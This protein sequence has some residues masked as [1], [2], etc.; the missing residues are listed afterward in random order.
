MTGSPDKASLSVSFAWILV[1]KSKPSSA[2]FGE[3]GAAQSD[4]ACGLLAAL[5][6]SYVQ[7]ASNHC[8]TLGATP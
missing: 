8:R 7:F 1:V 2:D 3:D 4:V 5:I 6:A